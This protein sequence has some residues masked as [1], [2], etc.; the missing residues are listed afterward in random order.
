MILYFSIILI[1]LSLS[2]FD[3]IV[4][5]NPKSCNILLYSSFNLNC[6]L[7]LLLDVFLFSSYITLNAISIFVVSNFNI[8]LL[9]PVS[10][11]IYIVSLF[12]L[13]KI[14]PESIKYSSNNSKF[15]LTK[16]NFSFITKPPSL[17]ITSSFKKVLSNNSLHIS[18]N[19]SFSLVEKLSYFSSIFYLLYIIFGK[20]YLLLFTISSVTS[21]L[22]FVPLSCE[23]TTDN[24]AFI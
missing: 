4:S 22:Y 5:I 10:F 9:L 19:S 17:L 8:T 6:T 14:H 7:L 24:I 21:T 20:E 23:R 13:S 16:L 11:L 18:L 12:F 3:G 1:L 2:V 15:R